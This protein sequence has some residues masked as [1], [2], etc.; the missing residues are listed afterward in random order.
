[1]LFS[2]YLLLIFLRRSLTLSPRLECS[3]AILAHRNL[4]LPGSSDSPASASWEAGTTGTHHHAQ[5]IFVFLVETGFHHVGQNGLDL[6]TSWYTRLSL[7]KCWDCRHE[8]P[9]PAFVLFCFVFL[10][11]HFTL[12]AQAGVQWCNLSL[13]QPLPPGFKPF[14]CFSLTSSW[15]YRHV[16][17]RPANF[18]I[19][20]RDGVSPCWSG[21]SQTPELRWFARLGL[22]KCWDYRCEPP[23]LGNS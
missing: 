22:P 17:P 16:S 21:W 1:M 6:L 23:C 9:G 12:V 3:D 5:L 14:S 4:C 15:D 13:P 11:W 20:S 10:R 2:I 8:P 19:F 18:C 7:P